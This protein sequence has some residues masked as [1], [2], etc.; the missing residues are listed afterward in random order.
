MC[1]PSLFWAILPL[2]TPILNALRSGIVSEMGGKAVG[3][4]VDVEPSWSRSFQRHWMHPSF[5]GELE[6]TGMPPLLGR[7]SGCHVFQAFSGREQQ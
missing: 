5:P 6:S 3:H 7:Q 4:S 1:D 2:H